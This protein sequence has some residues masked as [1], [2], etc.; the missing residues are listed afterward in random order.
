MQSVLGVQSFRCG[1]SQ[2]RSSHR[3]KSQS[4]LRVRVR[5]RRGRRVSRKGARRLDSQ[6]KESSVFKSHLENQATKQKAV[7]FCTEWSS[8]R[9]EEVVGECMHVVC[10]CVCVCVCKMTRLL[11]RLTA[12]QQ[13]AP[14]RPTRQQSSRGSGPGAALSGRSSSLGVV[15]AVKVGRRPHRSAFRFS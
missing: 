12:R 15:A 8:S 2:L 6:A 10:V 9:G 14:K 3:I 1:L 4:P 11:Y 13:V 7:F 5:V